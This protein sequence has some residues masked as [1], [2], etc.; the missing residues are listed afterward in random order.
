MTTPAHILPTFSVVICNYNYAQYIE[1]AVDSVLAQDYSPE[2]VQ[3]VVVDD[4]STDGSRAVLEGYRDHPQ[5]TLVFQQN[6][7][8]TGAFEAGVRAS[9]GDLVCLLDSDDLCEANRLSRISDW[10]RTHDV[11]VRGLF[12][13]HDLTLRDD[14]DGQ[15][16]GDTWFSVVGIDKLG[17]SYDLDGPPMFFPFSVPA[18]LVFDRALIADC[19]A[20]I[21]P[22]VFPRGADGA[23]CPAALIKSGRVHYLRESLG[24]YR[25]HAANEFASLQ[26]GR[27][28]PRIDLRDRTPRQL[29][30]LDQWVDLAG[31]SPEHHARARGYFRRWERLQR[32][33]APDRGA[34]PPQVSIA[35]IGSGD[36]AALARSV[37]SVLDQRH[38]RCELV[39]PD[40]VPP[41]VPPVTLPLRR[42][43]RVP[44][45][46]ALAQ[47]VDAAQA[48]SGES[49]VFL[50][51]G[52]RL[53]RDFVDRHLFYRQYGAL[54]GVTCSD[55][56]LVTPAGE[57]V[58]ANVY[59]QSGAWAQ[60]VQQIPPFAT[61][62]AQWVAPPLAACMFRRDLLADLPGREQASKEAW[63]PS[64]AR[65]GGWL[66]LQLALHTTGL[67]RFRETLCSVMLNSGA[68]ASYG[69]LSAPHAP[70]G[71]VAEVSVVEAAAWLRG[72]HAAHREV[73]A[74]A[75]P[76][77][78]HERFATWL[79]AQR[80]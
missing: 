24:I 3:V 79:D 72:W 45:A 47:M 14:R 25:I 46:G 23:L 73:L 64:L 12:L 63:P 7:G 34:L 39:L 29:H 1:Q 59:A 75:L 19:L 69:W 36:A 37:E 77:V 61:G 26:G 18:G 48:A 35:L 52:D 43:A 16:A 42:Y 71:S 53:D 76:A 80:G 62:L 78:W 28:T 49:I 44:D 67:L 57:L 2:R 32:C 4:G 40:D 55:I 30:F 6:C 8:Q 54:V 11:P 68:Q 38:P 50:P 15:T 65:A 33:P 66:P 13:C 58:H 20:A 41:P 21:P 22:W 70:D 74:A 60:Q 17:D 51:L 56:R 31:L 27:Y 5:V 10:L 9:A